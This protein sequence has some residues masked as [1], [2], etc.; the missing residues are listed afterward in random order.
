MRIYNKS[1]LIIQSYGISYHKFADD[2]QLYIDFDPKSLF[3]MEHAKQKL[4]SCILAL[5]AWMFT[6][7]LKF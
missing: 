3:D 4:S 2:T 6:N 5:K 1:S 7:K